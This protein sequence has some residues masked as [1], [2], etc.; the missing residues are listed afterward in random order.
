MLWMVTPVQEQLTWLGLLVVTASSCA[1]RL[2]I[3]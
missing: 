3:S 2:V 1:R